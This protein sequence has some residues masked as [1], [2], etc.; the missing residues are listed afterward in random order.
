MLVDLFEIKRAK[1]VIICPVAW[2]PY[3]AYK[4]VMCILLE[5]S[6]LISL[7]FIIKYD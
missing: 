6:C 7:S 5:V 3:C 1:F 2:N 4:V